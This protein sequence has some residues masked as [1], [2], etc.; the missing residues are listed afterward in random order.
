MM[1]LTTLQKQ[2]NL[3]VASQHSQGKNNAYLEEKL[4]IFKVEMMQ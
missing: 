1:T 4:R 3:L 2:W